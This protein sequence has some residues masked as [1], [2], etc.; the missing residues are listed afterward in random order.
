MKK[1]TAFLLPA[2]ALLFLA[3]CTKVIDVN[4]N[5]TSAKLVIEARVS[6]QSGPQ[7][8]KLT[9]TVNFDTDNN[10]PPVTGAS[11]ILRDIT[12]GLAD[13]LDEV[14]AGI[15]ESS[16]IP[17]VQGH[18]YNL[19]INAEGK[20]Y[21]SSSTMPQVVPFDSLYS[22]D[23]SVFGELYKNMVP[24]YQDPAGVR[25]YYRFILTVNGHYKEQYSW[26][27]RF[28]DGRRNVSALF[29]EGAD[30]DEEEEDERT[31]AGDTA[32]VEMQCVDE[33]AFRYFDSFYQASGGSDAPAN[34]VSNIQGG[35]LGYFSAYTTR[36]RTIIVQ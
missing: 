22:E 34:P 2:V 18:T 14:S 20:T 13:T 6:D 1:L 17:G 32:T 36:S 35:A 11:V 25:N 27:D 31:K 30:E 28:S 9:K 26:D 24:I 7:R 10:F 16:T 12:A 4:L 29:D 23:F 5:N 8:V 19:V 15:Y 3:S 21:T 33:A